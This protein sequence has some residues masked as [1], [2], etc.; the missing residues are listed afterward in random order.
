M[1]SD[2]RFYVYKIPR[3]SK[4]IQTETRLLVAR[5]GRDRE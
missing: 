2:T 5:E 1:K 4:S 3:L